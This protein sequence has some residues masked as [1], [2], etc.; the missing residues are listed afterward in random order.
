[1]DAKYVVSKFGENKEAAFNLAQKVLAD[2]FGAA[3]TEVQMID[4]PHRFGPYKFAARTLEAIVTGKKPKG[5]STRHLP[6]FEEV[7]A[8][9]ATNKAVGILLHG[10]NAGA[11]REAQGAKRL[12]GE[13]YV[14]F[15]LLPTDN[16]DHVS[17]GDKLVADAVGAEAANATPEP[18][19]DAEGPAPEAPAEVV[20]AA[21]VP[22][23]TVWKEP[24][25]SEPQVDWGALETEAAAAA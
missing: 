23:D 15:G 9:I 13:A 1:M 21:T 25:S 7:K 22:S 17:L 8:I 3:P 2:T 11:V 14:F 20:P 5:I 16:A 18:V 12:Q 6:L 4:H 19:G 10:G 24:E